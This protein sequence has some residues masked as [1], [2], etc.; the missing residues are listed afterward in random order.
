M[1]RTS[2]IGIILGVIAIGVG[3]V[4]KGVSPLSLLN[5]AA[6]LIIFAGTAAAILI[7]FPMNEIK[8]IPSLLK[9]FLKNSS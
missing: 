3:M 1:D 6:L 9:S 8:K 5:P 4:L 2:F 7:A